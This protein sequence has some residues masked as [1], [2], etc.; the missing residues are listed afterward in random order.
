MRDVAKQISEAKTLVESG[1]YE[2][3]LDA[4]EQA[5]IASAELHWT[6]LGAEA[7]LVI[8]DA[9]SLLGDTHASTQSALSA[10]VSEMES[11]SWSLAAS[12]ADYLF[13]AAAESGSR[14][15]QELWQALATTAARKTQMSPILARA[16]DRRRRA[17][18]AFQTEGADAAAVLMEAALEDIE[19][20]AGADSLKAAR[21]PRRTCPIP[22]NCWRS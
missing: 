14:T 22:T 16:L 3:G 15:D 1:E 13:W 5:R 4:A 11:T 21:F 19:S 12:A 2:K 7:E 17:E 8:A 18:R 20:A 10:F 6:P 9:Q